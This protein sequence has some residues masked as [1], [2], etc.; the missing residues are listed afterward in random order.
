MADQPVSPVCAKR[1]AAGPTSA[2]DVRQHVAVVQVPRSD[3]PPCNPDGVVQVV[4]DLDQPR[5]K[6]AARCGKSA[7]KVPKRPDGG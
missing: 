4:Q 6:K 2:A 5:C 7:L 3:A 1:A